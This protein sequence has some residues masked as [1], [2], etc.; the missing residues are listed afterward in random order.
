MLWRSLSPAALR[1]FAVVAE[2]PI[3]F[4]V[5]PQKEILFFLWPD[6]SGSI[7]GASGNVYQMLY[8]FPA[9]FVADL[10]EITRASG[11]Y[12][13]F[14]GHLIIQ[15]FQSC[16]KLINCNSIRCSSVVSGISSEAS[17]LYN[18]SRS[19]NVVVVVFWGR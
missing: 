2:E 19:F 7:C 12:Q 10:P 3:P 13:R 4:S 11:I 17:M 8:V 9:I 6:R 1:V 16:N 14:N 15:V 5:A 18:S